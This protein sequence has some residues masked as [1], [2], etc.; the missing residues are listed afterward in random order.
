M[1]LHKRLEKKKSN[2]MAKW[3]KQQNMVFSKVTCKT[4]FDV[5]T[6]SVSS[7]S[8]S[9][10]S[11]VLASPVLCNPITTHF[12]ILWFSSATW[13]TCFTFEAMQRYL[14]NRWCELQN[15]PHIVFFIRFSASMRSA[16]S[17]NLCSI[18]TQ[19]STD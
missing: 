10:C 8:L 3:I 9:T 13:Q 12:P 16:A 17:V 19:R 6:K 7:S 18:S 14:K 2:L 4:P 5:E 1:F 15:W 11:M